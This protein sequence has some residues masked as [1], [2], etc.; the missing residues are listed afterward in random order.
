MK[1]PELQNDDKKTK[2]LR[3][4]ELAECWKDIKEV[5]HYQSLLYIS[6][7]ICLE[8]INRHHNNLFADH[9]GIEKMQKLIDKKYYWS[10]LQKNFKNYIKDYNICLTSKAICHKPYKN[11]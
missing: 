10:I 5:L 3:S 6:K 9:F 7:V 4:E 1:F 11:L 8:L 2:K